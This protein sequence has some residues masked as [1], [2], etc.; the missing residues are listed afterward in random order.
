M[1]LHLFFSW[2]T[3]LGDG[4]G[5]CTAPGICERPPKEELDLGI[6]TAQLVGGPPRQGVVDGGVE[7][8]QNALSFS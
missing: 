3:P 8:E 4:P 5:R 6:G 1:L 7:S 2:T